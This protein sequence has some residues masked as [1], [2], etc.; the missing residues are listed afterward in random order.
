MNKA[1]E[2]EIRN[3][4]KYFKRLIDILYSKEHRVSTYYFMIR[5]NFGTK[6]SY[7]NTT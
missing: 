2:I 1:L 7:Q 6:I 4:F 5:I 3:N